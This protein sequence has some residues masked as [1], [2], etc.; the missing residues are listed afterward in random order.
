MPLNKDTLYKRFQNAERRRTNWR[1]TYK[2]ALEY[3]SPQRDTFDHPT[4]GAKR[5]NTDRVFDSTGQDALQK[6][7]STV[8]SNI[9][10]PQRN[11]VS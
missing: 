10:P 8:H 3:F 9:F 2:E 5:T 6:A 1:N 4:P 11:G 7:V